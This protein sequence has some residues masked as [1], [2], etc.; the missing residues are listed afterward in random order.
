MDYSIPTY[1]LAES[2]H[3]KVTRPEAHILALSDLFAPSRSEL[4]VYVCLHV[5][6]LLVSVVKSLQLCLQ[7]DPLERRTVPD[8]SF[9]RSRVDVLHAQLLDFLDAQKTHACLGFCFED[10]LKLVIKYLFIIV[11]ETG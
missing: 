8:I 9:H 2:G 7:A 11:F 3:D 6:L 5:T 10:C 4:N 1:S